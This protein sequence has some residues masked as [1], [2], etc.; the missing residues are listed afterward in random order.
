MAMRTSPII[1]QL[2]KLSIGSSGSS[3]SGVGVTAAAA[4]C[5]RTSIRLAH[6]AKAKAKATAK[7]TATAKSKR[8]N[9]ERIEPSFE[10]GH[11][12][13]I[14]V[15]NHFVA[16]MTVYSHQ[17][18][19]KANHAF[20]QIPFNGKKLRP[21]KLRKDYWRPMAL[22]QF[23]E[24]QG[25]VGRSVYQRLREC[26]K[27]HEYAWDDGVLYG[28]DGRT[29]TTRERGRRL[30]DQRAN[31]IAD[32][33]AV[34][35]GLGKGNRIVFG[36]ADAANADA[37][38]AVDADG[39]EVEEGTRTPPIVVEDDGKRLLEATVWWADAL[40]RNY[41]SKWSKNVKHE[42]FEEAALQLRESVEREME[43]EREEG[44]DGEE[45]E[46]GDK[47]QTVPAE[48]LAEKEPTKSAE[49]SQRL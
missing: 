20:R 40:D 49:Q 42:L 44:E 46:K 3:S 9:G 45:G 27:L 26:K 34:L 47:S 36:E 41:A 35:S 2:G 43:M 22:I 12:E 21:A 18:V 19:L 1:A 7:A 37:T 10:P 29:L 5:P 13:K 11:G 31:T 16:G 14:Y 33:A 6:T 15:F 4:G 32:M 48:L 17:P 23:P 38:A 28:P 39:A 8:R 25:E 24:G 30:N